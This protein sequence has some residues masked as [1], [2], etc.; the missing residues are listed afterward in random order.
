M[1][2]SK[3]RNKPRRQ[4]RKLTATQRRAKRE[5]RQKFQMIFINGRQKWVPR[6]TLIDGLTVNEFI[7]RN[8]DPIWLVQNELWEL[9]PAGDET[10]ALSQTSDAEGPS[11][12]NVPA[13][14]ITPRAT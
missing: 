13:L 9:I 11:C 2:K 10:P 5:R 3:K 8:A 6:E 14:P 4:K 1:T 12:L 7:A